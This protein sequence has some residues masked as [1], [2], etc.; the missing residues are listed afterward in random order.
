MTFEEEHILFLYVSKIVKDNP[1]TIS[2]ITRAM[3]VGA[4]E[5]IKEA[6]NNQMIME[7]VTSQALESRRSMTERK[8]HIANKLSELKGDT[9]LNWNSYIE[10]YNG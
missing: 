6:S 1:E 7:V 5:R 2:I 10:K 9:F 4:E 3:T 8:K